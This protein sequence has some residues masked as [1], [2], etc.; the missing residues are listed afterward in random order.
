[1]LY[2]GE[3]CAIIPYAPCGLYFYILHMESFLNVYDPMPPNYQI[4]VLAV[5]IILYKT[6]LD[7]I[8]QTF[9]M[10]NDSIQCR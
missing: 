7:T 2:V 5:V 10:G 4:I 3:L 1:M 9:L 6:L 8:R